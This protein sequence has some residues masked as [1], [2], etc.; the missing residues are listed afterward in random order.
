M[1]CINRRAEG[2]LNYGRLKEAEEK[3]DSIGGPAL[4]LNLNPQ[5]LSDTEPPKRQHTSADMRPP[6]HIK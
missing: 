6:T 4:L 2:G 3:G 5:D 1:Y